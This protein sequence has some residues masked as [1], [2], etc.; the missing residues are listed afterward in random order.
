MSDFHGLPPVDRRL[1]IPETIWVVRHRRFVELSRAGAPEEWQELV[2]SDESVVTRLKDGMWPVS[3]STA[4]SMMAQIIE[5]LDL[6]PGMRVLEIGT[7]TG[8]NAACFAALGAE[9]VSVEVDASVADHARDALR[10]AGR[11]EVVVITGDGESGAPSHGPFDR[12]IATAAAHT[13][14]RAW[15][16]QTKVGGVIVVPWAATF[17]P[18]GPL[19]VLVVK[20]DGSAE[21]RFTAPARFMPLRGQQLPPMVRDET[22]ERWIAAGRPEASRYGVT[23]TSAGQIVWLDSPD[24]PVA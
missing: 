13:V 23:V 14:P 1:F 19:A 21:G 4:P 17:H 22:E 15:I 18:A 3:S 20:G 9:V 6:K 24:S 16:E 12:V 2:M 11:P 5:S 10:A 7:G 8:Y